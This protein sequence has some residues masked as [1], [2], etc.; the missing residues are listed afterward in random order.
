MSILAGRRARS[1][2]VCLQFT[3]IVAGR[4]LPRYYFIDYYHA[5]APVRRARRAGRAMTV[6]V[7]I[8]SAYAFTPLYGAASFISDDVFIFHDI[9]LVRRCDDWR[10]SLQAQIAAGIQMMRRQRDG[11]QQSRGN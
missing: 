4:G 9:Y 5:C 1:H 6:A 11:V 2:R 10:H 3:D 7:T 8:A